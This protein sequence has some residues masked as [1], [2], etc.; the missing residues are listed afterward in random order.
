MAGR[1]GQLL[2]HWPGEGRGDA[3]GSGTGVTVTEHQ[4]LPSTSNPDGA[5]RTAGAWGSGPLKMGRGDPG[6]ERPHGCRTRPR[7]LRASPSLPSSSSSGKQGGPC[8]LLPGE[9]QGPWEPLDP[10][11][12]QRLCKPLGSVRLRAPLP[13]TSSASLLGRSP[14]RG[15]SP[16][17][18]TRAPIPPGFVPGGLCRRG[19]LRPCLLPPPHFGLGP[20]QGEAALGMS[21]ERRGPAT[22]LCNSS[23]LLGPA[24]APLPLKRP[25]RTALSTAD[26]P[27]QCR[28]E[29]LRTGVT[30]YTF[31]PVPPPCPQ[32]NPA[33]PE[34]G[35]ET[36][37]PHC[38]APSSSSRLGTER[39]MRIQG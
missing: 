29:K 22:S 23:H 6:I 5:Q 35:H 30:V 25:P 10:R 33:L 11:C 20:R 18:Q 1:W 38:H 13:A 9:P 8:N 17:L 32:P 15:S 31:L 39:E 24:D 14:P 12:A 34:G 2:S 3:G 4:N 19:P 16:A 27:Q 36:L 26:K 28:R 37:L 21:L 7:P